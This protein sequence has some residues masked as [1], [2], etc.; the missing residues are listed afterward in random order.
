MH[1]IILD[2]NMPVMGGEEALLHLRRIR[3]DVPVILTS[4]YNQAEAMLRMGGKG[5]S[6]FLQKPFTV[7]Q[8]AAKLR[9][10][11]TLHNPG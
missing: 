7:D 8:V 1:A 10:L 4:G 9:D 11:L 5:V 3:A 6:A 2:L